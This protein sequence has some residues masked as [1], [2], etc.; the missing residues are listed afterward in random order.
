MPMAR[1]DMRD[2]IRLKRYEAECW[3]VCGRGVKAVAHAQRA[4]DATSVSYLAPM[5]PAAWL[6]TLPCCAHNAATCFTMWG[7]GCAMER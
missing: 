5:R 1:K 2:A 4:G 7:G 3:H 6:A